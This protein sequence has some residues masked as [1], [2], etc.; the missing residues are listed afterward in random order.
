M[1]IFQEE[2]GRAAMQAQPMFS[3]VGLEEWDKAA[4]K[5]GLTSTNDM[6]LEPVYSVTNLETGVTLDTVGGKD[7]G[8]NMTADE[9]LK[10]FHAETNDYLNAVIDIRE[11]R[12]IEMLQFID[13]SVK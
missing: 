7:V 12:E 10:R 4:T 9:V 2:N 8:A 6:N 5:I 11:K 13:R 3:G 1:V